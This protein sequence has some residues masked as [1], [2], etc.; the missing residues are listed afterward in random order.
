VG[1]GA[2]AARGA[3]LTARG[4]YFIGLCGA[5]L[6]TL[7]AGR[8]RPDVVLCPAWPPLLQG[9]FWGAVYAAGVG[10][11]SAC[12][13]IA[14]REGAARSIR[15]VLLFGALIHGVA[16]CGAP[17]LSQDPL[18][19]A[20][21]GKAL[22]LGKGAPLINALPP[23]DPFL[24]VL[25][26]EWRHGVS[27]YGPGFHFFARM[28]ARAAG[29][30]LWLHLRIY[31]GVGLGL[32][33]LCA[34]LCGKAGGPR[35]AALLLLCPIAVVEGTQTPH[36]DS[37]LALCVSAWLVLLRLQRPP[38]L[39]RWRLPAAGAALVPGLL[40]KASA[41]LFLGFFGL[42]WLRRRVAGS[43]RRWWP[44][45]AAAGLLGA[46][47]LLVLTW[48]RAE[49]LYVQAVRPDLPFEYC[50]RS[51][52]CLPRVVLRFVLHAPRAAWMVGLC[53]RVAGAG[54]V[55]FCALRA[56]RAPL[57]DSAP[58]WGAT[59]L[60]FYYLYLHGWAQSWYLLPLL[61]LLP[62][63][64]RRIAPAL[65]AYCISAALYYGLALPFTCLEDPLH[66]AL[67]DLAQGLLTIVPPTVALLRAG[68]SRLP[69]SHR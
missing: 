21:V 4:T 62:H 47:L 34:A 23:N 43:W 20:A 48:R 50:T 40:C 27:A 58:R 19:Y 11:L 6:L 9:A 68:G 26:E 67:A 15:E 65:R 32:M 3:H 55:L 30:R 33:L 24:I 66:I 49:A 5:A 51:I 35:A 28:V 69:L 36:N 60:F 39:R 37:F 57:A 45:I 25:P 16:L 1:G 12:W 53:F 44:L 29:D 22:A 59:L 46:G 14:S 54:L 61:P 63:A 18:Y 52:E 41:L 38:W 64:P 31:Q 10:L 7:P 56:A 13:L 8:F 17:Y 42:A 2:Q